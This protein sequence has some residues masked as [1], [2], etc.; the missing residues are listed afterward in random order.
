[1]STQNFQHKTQYVDFN[2]NQKNQK[3]GVLLNSLGIA[4]EA[5][6]VSLD[7]ALCAKLNVGDNFVC[8]NP[9]LP[10]SGKK[11]GDKAFVFALLKAISDSLLGR[12]N[13]VDVGFSL[14]NLARLSGSYEEN[15]GIIRTDYQG[16]FA[17]LVAN[18]A[19]IAKK[20]AEDAEKFEETGNPIVDAVKR[21][22]VKGAKPYSYYSLKAMG[23]QLF[24]DK[25]LAWVEA[26]D[27]PRLQDEEEV[28]KNCWIRKQEAI[29]ELLEGKAVFCYF[30][31]R[32]AAYVATMIQDLM[33]PV[34]VLA[35]HR[36]QRIAAKK[37]KTVLARGHAE[38]EKGNGVVP[39]PVTNIIR[40]VNQKGEFSQNLLVPVQEG[41][42]GYGL[43]VMPVGEYAHY[44]R[45]GSILPWLVELGNDPESRYLFSKE[46]ASGVYF[47]RTVSQ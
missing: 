11:F 41:E 24:A 43:P 18:L 38:I 27:D 36:D 17:P 5:M 19:A 32:T 35:E 12:A 14:G 16:Q 28:I 13:A 3:L 40:I 22:M 9:H 6:E 21:A 31:D 26:S 23:G 42:L 4:T 34:E 33:G 30:N 46:A 15:V 1:M 45:N 7:S 2:G 39:E 37:V 44:S 20:Q 29:D 25:K 47:A 10:S 8:F